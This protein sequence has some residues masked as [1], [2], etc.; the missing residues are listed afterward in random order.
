MLKE[1]RKCCERHKKTNVLIK[2][3]WC[4]TERILLAV[5]T[6]AII[7]VKIIFEGDDKM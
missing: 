2:E 7:V 5:L 3:D 6:A 4:V 1:R